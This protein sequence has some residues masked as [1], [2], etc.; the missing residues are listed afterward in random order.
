VNKDT[1]YKSQF[2]TCSPESSIGVDN[3]LTIENRIRNLSAMKKEMKNTE[4]SRA[5]FWEREC[6]K[7]DEEI[8]F[9]REEARQ[10]Q[11]LIGRIISQFSERWDEVKLTNFPRPRL[12]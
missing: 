10:C 7:K 9:Y 12:K 8:K 2:L 5:V 6:L 11:E 1:K 3:Y 4:E